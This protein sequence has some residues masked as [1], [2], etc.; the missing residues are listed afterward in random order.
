MSFAIVWG[1]KIREVDLGSVGLNCAWCGEVTVGDCVRVDEASHVYYIR[2]KF[3]EKGRYL[4]CRL[5]AIAQGVTEPDLK[6]ERINEEMVWPSRE[7]LA[8]TNPVLAAH[9]HEP[10]PL[11]G[12]LPPGINRRQWAFLSGLESAMERERAEDRVGG[13][14]QGLVVLSAIACVG[15]LIYIVMQV[16]DGSRWPWVCVWAAGT[17]LLSYMLYRLNR[18]MLFRA[19]FRRYGPHLKRHL[20]ATVAPMA[21]LQKAAEALGKS[22]RDIRRFLDWAASRV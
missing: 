22:R 17:G 14:I 2:G 19:T 3:K 9:P 11:D 8:A 4:R 16:P 21:T 5:C 7:I 6:P 18:W 12:E 13:N 10:A 1:T 20:R 15:L